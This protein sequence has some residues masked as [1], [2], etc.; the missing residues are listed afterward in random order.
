MTGRV[1]VLGI[2]VVDAVYRGPGL[3]RPG[4]TVL[5][6]GY[7]LGPGGKG[8][9]Q[10]VAAAR[11]GAATIFITKLG[12]DG[13]AAMGRELWQAAGIES[14]V[15]ESE[16]PT[17]SAGI[18]IDEPTG[19]NAILVCPAAAGTLSPSDVEGA[20]AAIEGASVFV[21]QLEQ[22]LDA[23]RRG[24]EIA[25]AAGLVTVLNPAPAAPLDD[26]LLALCD[27]I[28]PN[29]GEAA[30]L[31]G[32][33]VMDVAS[34]RAAAEALIARGA[35]GAVVTLGDRGAVL[36]GP[37]GIA[38]IPA[39]APG[40]AVDTTGAGDV[41]TGAFAARLA[42]GAAPEAAARFASTAAGIA[43]TRP[44]AAASAPS[45]AETEALL[46]A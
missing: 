41:F 29:E 43:V 27:W 34:A 1:C 31:T 42:E 17:G 33:P 9:N 30:A 46:H 35:G 5:G 11:A 16:M 22:P 36:L 39:I 32:L 25:R 2:F 6:S 12:R 24:L 18:F 44:G 38:T 8:S 37:A 23:A 13:F 3:P 10:A 7:A 20:R 14:H 21:T 19:Q 40:K 28:I 45:R 26:A 15:V 4:E